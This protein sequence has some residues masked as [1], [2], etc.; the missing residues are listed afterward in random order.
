LN[1]DIIE[2]EQLSNLF[3]VQSPKYV[4]TRLRVNVGVVM[5]HVT[6]HFVINKLM[7]YIRIYFFNFSDYSKN[8]VTT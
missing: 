8:G 4:I 2:I 7:Q 3:F 5:A 6:V 1:F